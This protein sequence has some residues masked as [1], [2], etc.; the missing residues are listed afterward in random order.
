MTKVTVD[1]KC[2]FKFVLNDDADSGAVR[3][4][5]Q[6]LKILRNDI[7]LYFTQTPFRFCGQIMQNC[8][9]S[10][11]AVLSFIGKPYLQ[12]TCLSFL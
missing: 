3:G 12:H 8:L 11:V 10:L 9:M 1:E 7:F 5:K 6:M 4:H 2:D